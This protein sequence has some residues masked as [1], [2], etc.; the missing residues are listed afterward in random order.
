M[1]IEQGRMDITVKG[2]QVPAPDDLSFKQGVANVYNSIMQLAA[3][4]GG[5][6]SFQ[7][8][9]DASHPFMLEITLT[10]VHWISEE[11]RNA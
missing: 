8:S 4:V 2:D 3:S 11:Y 5:V 1:P 10:S 6:R 9:G 7:V